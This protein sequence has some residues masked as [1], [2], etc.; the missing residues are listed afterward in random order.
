ME[1]ASDYLKVS[2][3]LADAHNNQNNQIAF[4]SRNF[5]TL[6]CLEPFH[7]SFSFVIFNFLFTQTA[8]K[9]GR[10]ALLSSYIAVCFCNIYNLD[11]VYPQTAFN[12]KTQEPSEPRP[13]GTVL[14]T[15]K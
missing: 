7:S 4:E 12:L 6:I 9:Y 13:A 8:S 1:M 14:L 11:L 10:R 2:M 3:Q 5:L 15:P